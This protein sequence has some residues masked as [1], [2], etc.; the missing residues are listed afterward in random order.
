MTKHT[1]EYRVYYEDTD[2][3]GIV[4]HANYLKFAERA[5]TEWLRSL[6]IEQLELQEKKQ[7]SFVVYHLEIQFF[8]PAKL[9]DLLTI[10]SLPKKVGK[11]RITMTQ[12]I[13][14]NAL[15]VASLEVSVACIDSAGKPVIF[16]Q[17]LL[18][19]LGEINS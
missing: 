8:S 9:D 6:G 12:D 15:K 18:S 7:L 13:E 2:A 17:V 4:Y 11:A 10:V 5:R 1:I 16:P 3:G 19:Q 14:C